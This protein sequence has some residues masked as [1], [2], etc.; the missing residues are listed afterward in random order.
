[1]IIDCLSPILIACVLNQ[2]RGHWF[3]SDDLNFAISVVLKLRNALEVLP[4]LQNFMEEES[5]VV[6][7]LTS[8]ASNIRKGSLCYVGIFPFFLKKIQKK[9]AHNMFSLMLTP[10]FKSL[11]LVFSF[12]RREQDVAIVEEYDNKSLYLLL[13]KCHHH[14]H[15]LAEFESV[16]TNIGVDEDYNLDIF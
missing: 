16:F 12:T 8:F 15:P 4:Y 11:R 9:K 14:L 7:E 5:I 6:E 13:L 2:S 1:M 10:R 3:L